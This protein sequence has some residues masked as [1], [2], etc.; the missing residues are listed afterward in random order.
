MA[1]IKK[2]SY[3]KEPEKFPWEAPAPTGPFWSDIK[4]SLAA[5]FLTIYGAEG[6]AQLN[7][8]PRLRKDEKLA[9]LRESTQEKLADGETATRAGQMTEADFK[10]CRQMYHAIASTYTEQ[11]NWKAAHEVSKRMGAAFEA[12]NGRE[13]AG[14]LNMLA[15]TSERMGEYALA[16]QYCVQ[17]LPYLRTHELCGPDS[18]QVLGTMRLRMLVLGKVG[19]LLEAKE[20]NREGYEVIASMKGGRFEKYHDEELEAMDELKTQLEM[21]EAQHGTIPEDWQP[22]E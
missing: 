20:L 14:A 15:W 17:T 3:E 9:Y 8:D 2:P 5:Q 11:R 18:P 21:A 6:L 7:L 13:D 12:R 10:L 4:E 16:D 19:R 1:S 22:S